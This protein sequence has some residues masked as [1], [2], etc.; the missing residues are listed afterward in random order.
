MVEARG[1]TP[2][3]CYTVPHHL[4]LDNKSST[5]QIATVTPIRARPQRLK[6]AWWVPN[7]SAMIAIAAVFPTTADHHCQVRYGT[8]GLMLFA[9]RAHLPSGLGQGA[10]SLNLT[11][12]ASKARMPR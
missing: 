6:K 8:V 11:H 4:A 1:R 12:S 10:R 2:S 5:R 7:P 9:S 3:L